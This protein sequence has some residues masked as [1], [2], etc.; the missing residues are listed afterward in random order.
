[1]LNKG[2]FPSI[3]HQTPV[4]KKYIK[5]IPVGQALHLRLEGLSDHTIQPWDKGRD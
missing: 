3:I 1:M 5:R 4:G 2:H